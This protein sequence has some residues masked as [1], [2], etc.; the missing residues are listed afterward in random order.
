MTPASNR[1]LLVDS[2]FFMALFEPRDQHHKDACE[3]RNRLKSSSFIV[4][5][6]ILYETINTRFVRRPKTIIQFESLLRTHNTVL[7]D[8]SSYRYGV[9]KNVLARTKTQ[10]HAMSLVDAV[11]SAILDDTNVRINAMLTFNLRDFGPICRKR[12]VE[13]L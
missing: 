11:L 1:T 2:G 10:S 5:W 13:L 6:P 8:D 7:L 3:K 9:Y 4:P 12:G